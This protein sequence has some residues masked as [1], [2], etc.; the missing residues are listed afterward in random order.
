MHTL[1]QAA[2]DSTQYKLGYKIG[3]WIPFVLLGIA[4]TVMIL[5]IWKKNKGKGTP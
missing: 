4:L 2:V 1:L 5:V 3:Q